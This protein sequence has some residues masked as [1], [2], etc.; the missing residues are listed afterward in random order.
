MVYHDNE[1]LGNGALQ[2]NVGNRSNQGVKKTTSIR[3]HKQMIGYRE[4]ET[5]PITNFISKTTLPFHQYRKASLLLF[6]ILL[7]QGCAAVNTFPTI[8]RPGDTVSVMVGGS[9]SARKNTIDVSLT[10]SSSTVW[11]LKALG[12]VRSVFNLRPDGRAYGLH[13]SSYFD[14]ENSWNKGHEPTQTVMVIDVPVGAALGSA[15][16]NV[17][18]NTSDDS[19]GVV[20]PFTMSLEIVNVPGLPGASDNFLRQNFDGIN[21]AVSFSDLEPA[22]YAKISFGEG[23]LSGFSATQG[24]TL[25]AAE[26]VVDFDETVVNGDDLDVYVAESTQK[27]TAFATGPFGDHQRMVSWRHDGTQLFINIIAPKGIEDRYLQVYVVHPRGLPGDPGLNLV[28]T[29]GYDLNGSTITTVPQFS[30][31][32]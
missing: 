12:L 30:Y 2:T 24:G 25:G 8:A 23:G 19:S 32:P 14:I 7:F 5:A 10:D 21:E 17:N 1:K 26:L 3:R 13:Y 11:D 29:T 20:Q 27:G 22:P 16:L 15:T 9:E 28:S 31:F 18:L 6:V 4:N